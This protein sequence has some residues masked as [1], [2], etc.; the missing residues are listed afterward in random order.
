MNKN[1]VFITE[2]TNV[3]EQETIIDIQFLETEIINIFRAIFK[4]CIIYILEKWV[5]II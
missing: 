1:K 5:L 2:K 4:I 3:W